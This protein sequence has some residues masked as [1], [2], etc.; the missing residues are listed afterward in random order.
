MPQCLGILGGGNHPRCTRNN[1]LEGVARCPMHAGVHTRHVAAGGE[2]LA[3][4]CLMWMTTGHWCARPAAAGEIKCQ[5][6]I[7]LHARDHVDREAE[8]L[9]AFL[10]FDPRPHWHDV[11]QAIQ[12]AHGLSLDRRRRVAFHYQLEM[13]P[14]VRPEE[15]NAY[16][17]WAMNEARGFHNP[18]PVGPAPVGIQPVPPAPARVPAVRDPPTLA[19]IATDNQSVHTTAVSEQTNI[20]LQKLLNTPIPANQRTLETFAF[21][22]LRMENATWGDVAN[23]VDD[24]SIWYAKK[25]CRKANDRLYQKT[26]DGLL[27]YILNIPSTDTK[28]E[29]TRRTYEECV[30][31]KNMCCEGHITRLCNVLVGFDPDFASPVPKGEIL[32]NKIAAIAAMEIPAS[33][34][35]KQAYQVFREL[36]VPVG[37]WDPWVDALSD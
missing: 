11:A 31:A 9:N 26:L 29:L 6:H 25:M 33:E 34:K 36:D 16:Y 5:W 18:E 37:E 13:D 28:A 10:Q 4:N 2:P 22:W 12:N 30:D 14:N 23:T 3:G 32:Q 7:D 8:F 19:E 21:L 24:M 15:F 17:M 20:G 1:L 27:A 35:V